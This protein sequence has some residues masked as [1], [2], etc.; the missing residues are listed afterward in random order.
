VHEVEYINGA[1]STDLNSGSKVHIHLHRVS[2]PLFGNNAVGIDFAAIAIATSAEWLLTFCL[3][4]YPPTDD[5]SWLIDSFDRGPGQA[6]RHDDF[7]PQ[8]IMVLVEY[9]CGRGCSHLNMIAVVAAD[10]IQRVRCEIE[11]H[12]VYRFHAGSLELS[13]PLVGS[14]KIY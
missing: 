4:M 5:L 7:K 11:L 3:W 2:F 13:K 1:D 10:P 8:A 12:C 9:L 14:I 6:F